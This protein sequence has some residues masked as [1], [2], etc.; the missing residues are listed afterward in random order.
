MPK[1]ASTKKTKQ[2]VQNETLN[3]K[4]KHPVQGAEINL[5]SKHQ[6]TLTLGSNY[7]P[8]KQVISHDINKSATNSA[9]PKQQA[10]KMQVKTPIQHN[11]GSQ[12]PKMPRKNSEASQKVKIQSQSHSINQAHSKMLSLTLNSMIK[13][14][15]ENNMYRYRNRLTNKSTCLL[16]S[17]FRGHY[18][19]PKYKA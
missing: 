19:I 11:K 6:Q 14:L 7:V 12:L 13:E 2:H 8:K 9:K 4:V 16:P 1:Q 15:I 18:K 10:T 17:Q 3:S 5:K